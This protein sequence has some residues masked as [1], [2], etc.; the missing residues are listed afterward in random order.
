MSK[1]EKAQSHIDGLTVARIILDFQT[2]FRD[3]YPVEILAAHGVGPLQSLI[4]HAIENG[5]LQIGPYADKQAL[6]PQGD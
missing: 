5:L 3:V 2:N 6:E 1:R 4:G